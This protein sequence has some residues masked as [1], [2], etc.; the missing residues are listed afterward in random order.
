MFFFFGAADGLPHDD[1]CCLLVLESMFIGTRVRNLYTT[2]NTPAE[3][4]IIENTF[5]IEN[6]FYIENTYASLSHVCTLRKIRT[7]RGRVEGLALMI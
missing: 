2:V 5:K 1:T 7:I 6:T 4:A 3:A